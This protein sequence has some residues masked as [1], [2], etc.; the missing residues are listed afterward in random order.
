MHSVAPSWQKGEGIDRGA[1]GY[2]Q[3][4]RKNEG[5][6][7]AKKTREGE[8]TH[9]VSVISRIQRVFSI[10][11]KAPLVRATSCLRCVGAVAPVPPKKTPER[12]GESRETREVMGE[13]ERKDGRKGRA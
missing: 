5:R 7:A 8:G 6:Q 3:R 9:Y 10:C 1:P 13:K 2:G 4:R 12:V 11:S